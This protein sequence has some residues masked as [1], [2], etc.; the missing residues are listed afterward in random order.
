MNNRF[1]AS[2]GIGEIFVNP[3]EMMWSKFDSSLFNRRKELPLFQLMLNL[4]SLLFRY[5]RELMRE[6]LE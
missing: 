3:F 1:I 4:A 2:H 6:Y 5:K